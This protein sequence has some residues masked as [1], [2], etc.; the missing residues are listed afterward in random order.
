[1]TFKFIISTV[2]ICV[3]NVS[4]AFSVEKKSEFSKEKLTGFV[5]RL[6]VSAVIV[7]YWFKYD[8]GEIHSSGEAYVKEQRP[9]QIAGFLVSPKKV[10][11]PDVIF[12]PRFI[13]KMT[14]NFK[15]KR[16]R[17]VPFSYMTSHDAML[18]ELEK[19]LPGSKPLTFD[20]VDKKGM[21]SLEYKQADGNFIFSITPFSPPLEV[22]DG[23]SYLRLIM[24]AVLLNK[25]G[26]PVT[27]IMKERVEAADSWTAPPLQWDSVSSRELAETVLALEKKIRE[28][29]LHISLSFRS[30]KLP[31]SN[32]MSMRYDRDENTSKTEKNTLGLM[33]GKKRVVILEKMIPR[34]TARL[35]GITLHLADNSKVDAAFA[36]SLA[37]WGVFTAESSKKFSSGVQFSP[38]SIYDRQDHLLLSGRIRIQGEEKTIE[39][40]RNRIG[41]YYRGLKNRIYPMLDGDEGNTFLFDINSRLLALPLL[42][43]KSTSSEYNWDDKHPALTPAFLLAESLAGGKKSSDLNNIPLQEKDENR[44][45]WMGIELQAMTPELAKVNN[46]SEQTMN[47]ETGAIVSYVYKD[48]PAARAGVRTGFVLLRLNISGQ[49][50]PADIRVD[51]GYSSNPFPWDQ[52]ER[53]P[54]EYLINMPLP[55]PQADNSL[56]IMLTDIGLGKKY[57]AVFSDS[58]KLVKKSMTIE[59]MPSHYSAAGEYND[60][61]LGL[62]VRDITYEVRRYFQLKETSPGVIVSRSD[63]GQPAAVAGLKK[64]EIITHIDGKPV[65]DISDF[66]KHIN[67]KKE[68]KLNVT[69][70][71]KQRVIKL[72]LGN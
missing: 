50:K 38:E 54:S 29:F 44:L 9:Y 40:Q 67:G 1:M 35:K 11:V 23:R 58:G 34:V 4:S 3:L 41:A 37:D 16:I 71:V 61:R 57:E 7:E 30:P 5:D 8:N 47:G 59:Q 62:R 32:R 52:Y 13:A 2:L 15:G 24:P 48:S 28:N 46:V 36:G 43:R 22:Q 49:Q 25:K 65:K 12:S 64:Y 27:V 45:A 21:L 56:N 19:T 53:I 6:S 72:K 33:L 51:G 42:E 60:I 66:E 10:L 14:V 18:L 17:A 63:S 68:L 20:S 31:P 26:N 39:V 69:R 55:W 70:M